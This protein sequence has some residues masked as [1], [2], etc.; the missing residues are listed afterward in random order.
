MADSTLKSIGMGRGL[1][2]IVSLIL[3][4]KYGIE[5]S[6]EEQMAIGD[7]LMMGGN[8]VAGALA[9]ISKLREKKA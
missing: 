2:A 3:A 1:I 5:L 8:L 6:E 4:A 7:L 9:I